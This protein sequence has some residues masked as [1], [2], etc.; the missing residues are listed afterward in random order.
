MSAPFRSRPIRP[1]T[2]L[3]AEPSPWFAPPTLLSSWWRHRSEHAPLP[4]VD[5]EEFVAFVVEAPDDV[6][7][8]G[9]VDA[10]HVPEALAVVAVVRVEEE[11]ERRGAERISAHP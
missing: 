7:D 5:H 6:A 3:L 10:G 4:R 11:Q 1:H 2:P 9:S 8:D